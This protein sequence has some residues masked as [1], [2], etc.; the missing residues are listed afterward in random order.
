MQACQ[1]FAE[2]LYTH[3][4]IRMGD[5]QV[6]LYSISVERGEENNNPHGQ[7]VYGLAHVL[8]D[9]ATLIKNEKALFKKLWASVNTLPVTPISNPNP[10]PN[11]QPYAYPNPNP[12]P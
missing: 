12:Q 11:P 5:G 3:M 2:A 6:I 9:D 10:N 8:I 7:G 4:Q 1:A